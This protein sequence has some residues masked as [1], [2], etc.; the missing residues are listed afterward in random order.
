MRTVRL[1]KLR[2]TRQGRL[3]QPQV[4]HAVESRDKIA[5]LP[6]MGQDPRWVGRSLLSRAERV[7]ISIIVRTR[8]ESRF[9]RANPR[10]A[11]ALLSVRLP[12][13]RFFD[14]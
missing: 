8:S 6:G 11:L 3:T 1:S 13:R 9:T 10:P 14:D 7:L 12:T 4:C 2:P 5:T